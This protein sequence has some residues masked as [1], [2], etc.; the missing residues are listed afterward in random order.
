MG[1]NQGRD[2]I[3][4]A[5]ESRNSRSPSRSQSPV[6][7]A[8][9]S[10]GTLTENVGVDHGRSDVRMAQQLLNGA[11]VAARLQKVRREGMAKGMTACRLRDTHLSDRELDCPLHRFLV[12]VVADLLARIDVSAERV[13]GKQVLP[14]PLLGV[15]REFERQCPG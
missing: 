14:T 11:Y 3:A 2:S 12:N 1:K 15:I 8:F 5:K 13:S 7:R 9:N 4:A 6:Q 10:H